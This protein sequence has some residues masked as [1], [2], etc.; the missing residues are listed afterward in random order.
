MIARTLAAAFVLAALILAFD[1]YVVV[2]AL[3]GR[4]GRAS[5]QE[6]PSQTVASD[7]F[8]TTMECRPFGKGTACVYE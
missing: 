3:Q 2:P 4:D 1:S 7:L 5:P 8:I 6:T